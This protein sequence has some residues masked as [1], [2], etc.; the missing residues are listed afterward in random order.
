MRGGEVHLIDL[1]MDLSQGRCHI[2]F[3]MNENETL[4]NRGR[5]EWEKLLRSV[6]TLNTF[7]Q[8]QSRYSDDMHSEHAQSNFRG[9][10]GSVS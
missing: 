2:E 3:D 8:S 7:C 4:R 1:S 9:N 6:I 10:W 5:G